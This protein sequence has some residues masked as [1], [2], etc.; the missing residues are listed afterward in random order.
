MTGAPKRRRK[1][2]EMGLK[3]PELPDDTAKLEWFYAFKDKLF[4]QGLFEKRWVMDLNVSWVDIE[5]QY[6]EDN[7]TDPEGAAVECAND[8]VAYD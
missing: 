8:W 2:V 4:A 5:A 7:E 6:Y 1:G 3:L